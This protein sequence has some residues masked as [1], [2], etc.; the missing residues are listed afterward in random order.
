MIT[1]IGVEV[2]CLQPTWA[3]IEK[4]SYRLYLND[5]LMTERT[6][7][8]NI[9]T[10]IDEELLVDVDQNI[11]H[12]LR[13]EV[14]KSTPMALTQLALR[15]IRGDNVKGNDRDGYRDNVTFV[16]E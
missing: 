4:C 16:L 13:V 14:I 5:E 6:W 11:N 10:Y 12:V 15:N 2:H 1:K 3:N 8:W 9:N 7:I